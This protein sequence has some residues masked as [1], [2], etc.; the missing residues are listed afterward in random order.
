MTY[1]SPSVVEEALAGVALALVRPLGVDA[2]VG[3]AAVVV[4]A[5]VHLLAR[6]FVRQELVARAA[7]TH[8]GAQGVLALMLAAAVV[9]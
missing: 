3:A 2:S 7:A 5:L 4:L 1:A 6:E 8:E 9:R